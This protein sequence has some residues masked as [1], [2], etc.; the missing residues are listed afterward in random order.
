MWMWDGGVGIAM[1]LSML[2][3]WGLVATAA[4]YALRT[5]AARSGP[6]ERR[7]EEILDE[8]YARGRISA[9]EYHVRRETRRTAH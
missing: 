5:A 6:R 4:V 2:V 7:A 3:F 1:W 8:R 9:D